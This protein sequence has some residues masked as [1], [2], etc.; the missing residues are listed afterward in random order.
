MS[1]HSQDSLE[2]PCWQEGAYIDRELAR[3]PD[4]LGSVGLQ[5]LDAASVGLADVCCISA[6]GVDDLEVM[7]EH[8]RMLVI[9]LGY[10]LADGRRQ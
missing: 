10:V 4:K 8:V 1:V 9:F 5:L 2:A 7:T 6:E 3:N